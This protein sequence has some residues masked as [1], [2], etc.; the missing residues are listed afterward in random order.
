MRCSPARRKPPPRRS[1]PPYFSLPRN[2]GEGRGGGAEDQRAFFVALSAGP[3]R[4]VTPQNT[5]MVV[6]RSPST[7]V[8]CAASVRN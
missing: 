4:F 8:R 6:A 1:N 5:G 2:A 3:Y 7:F